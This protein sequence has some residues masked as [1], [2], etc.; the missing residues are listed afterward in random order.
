MVALDP[1]EHIGLIRAFSDISHQVDTLIVDTAAG[2]ADSVVS[3]CRA[4]Q[5]V[6]LVVTDE[7]TSITDA[8]ALMKILSREHGMFKF[9]VVANMV[10]TPQE[11]RDLF[12]KLTRVAD[13]FL[14]V[15]LQFVCAIPFDEYVRKA[16][17]RQK[18]VMQ[19]YPGSNAAAAFRGLAEKVVKW[20]IKQD[21]SGH[22]EFFVERLIQAS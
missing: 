1:M 15:A 11:A 8:Y 13:Q 14:D 9:R 19:A 21:A 4:S 12:N 5:E 17:Q 3:F 16:V 6:L 18:P 20:P 22:L 7:P 2:I 10:R